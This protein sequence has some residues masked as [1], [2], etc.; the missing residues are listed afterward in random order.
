MIIDCGHYPTCF[1]HFFDIHF[2]DEYRDKQGIEDELLLATKFAFLCSTSLIIPM[3]SYFEN[4]VCRKIVDAIKEN[5][6]E[7]DI[8][9]MG[10][11]NSVEEFALSKLHQYDSVSNQ[12]K[13]Y[14]KILDSGIRGD[15][16]VRRKLTDTT[17]I[18]KQDWQNHVD[19]GRFFLNF[20]SLERV[21]PKDFKEKCN[22]MHSLLDGLA[23]IPEH[24]N[25]ILF[26]DLNPHSP[27]G[28]QV[29]SFI[30][31]SYFSS[32]LDALSPCAV[33]TELR[34]L[35]SEY[36]DTEKYHLHIP[37]LTILNHLSSVKLL[38]SI[39]TNSFYSIYK[40]KNDDKLIAEIAKSME[41]YFSARKTFGNLEQQFIN[42]GNVGAMGANITN[43]G[44][45]S[46]SCSTT[47][48]K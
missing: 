29:S 44:E 1:L 16:L 22:N 39:T 15:V 21:L 38:G 42:Y 27:L 8:F 36:V 13:I 9:F 20:S 4:D 40:M 45:M 41:R 7:Y 30:N 11:S 19:D 23:Y 47:V 3:S 31:K 10:N 2:L 14:Q 46:G 6:P 26:G 37:Y 18:I 24:I 33:V 43:T 35:Y 28:R 17:G 5:V 34:V 32:Y 12:H 25:K 48:E